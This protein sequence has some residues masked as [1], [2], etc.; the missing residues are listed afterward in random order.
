VASF[1]TTTTPFGS[2]GSIA[3]A[4]EAEKCRRSLAEFVR[5]GWS[6]IEPA[7]L[8]WN[9]HFDAVCDHLQA[10][11]EGDILRLIINMPPG[12][13]K[14]LLVCVFWPAW[15]WTRDPA[16]RSQFGSYDDELAMRDSTR[17]RDLVSSDW[18][19]KTFDPP[20]RLKKDQNTKHD[21]ANTAGGFRRAFCVGGKVT[22]HRG[23]KV[24]VDDPLAVKDQYN[25]IVKAKIKFLW[26]TALSTRVNDLR[27]A[28]RVI[29]MQRLADDDLTGEMLRQGGYEH[30]CLP[31]EFDPE[32]R[33]TTSI[34]WT[35]P[36]KEKGELLFPL[37][38][39]KSDLD[40]LKKEELGSDGYAGQ[41]QQQPVAEGGSKFKRHWFRRY[42]WEG[43]DLLRLHRVEHNNLGD[44][45]SDTDKLVHLGH[46][47]LFIS[48][49]PAVSLKMA[50]DPTG[51][52]LFAVTPDNDLIW[53]EYIC[54]RME[55]PDAINRILNLYNDRQLHDGG[56]QYAVIEDN[57][58]GK[59][60]I[61]NLRRLGVPVRA[62]TSTSD[63]IAMSLTARVRAEAGQIYVP[64]VGEWVRPA[65]DELCLFPAAAHDESVT[66]IS[67]AA[68]D[69]Y[70]FVGI[71][72]DADYVEYRSSPVFGRRDD[73][74]PD[75]R[76]GDYE[77]RMPQPGPRP[78]RR[79]AKPKRSIYGR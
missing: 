36:R 57:G 56:C 2:S 10:V 68:L 18:Y 28:R 74:P 44:R 51:I 11:T 75:L 8:D 34:G 19:I 5:R 16:I 15:E 7:R 13:A 49:D 3:R 23:D 65:L 9:F 27:M 67:L 24:V 78:S 25:P 58:V 20:W 53:L 45:I 79:D 4:I 55:E 39:P 1:I 62:I 69:V 30:L 6:A 33:C 63:K 77:V 72:K 61:Q 70:S 31:S 26:N 14:S 32:R 47:R 60:L 37:R 17:T 22:G 35:D 54:E 73:A 50:A 66:V 64:S 43:Q 12:H 21:F 52:G 48:G 59:P 42:T 76:D 46:C 29:V 41:H 71:A 38:F 40:R